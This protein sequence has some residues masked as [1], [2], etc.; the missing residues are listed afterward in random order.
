MPEPFCAFDTGSNLSSLKILT[1]KIDI[2]KVEDITEEFRVWINRFDSG[3]IL[4]WYYLL[5]FFE[6]KHDLFKSKVVLGK[7]RWEV[8][9]HIRLH[10]KRD[11]GAEELSV[12]GL[13][14]LYVHAAHICI[15]S[16]NAI[17][18][19]LFLWIFLLLPDDILNMSILVL[20]YT[21]TK[22]S[23]PFLHFGLFFSLFPVFSTFSICFYYFAG[24]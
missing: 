23:S 8:L 19:P 12:G 22:K 17:I 4:G 11:K 9:T 13:L 21:L 5:G 15:F 2:T 24:R 3:R 1:Y 6:F 14:G 7:V 16:L 20:Y 18:S 10:N